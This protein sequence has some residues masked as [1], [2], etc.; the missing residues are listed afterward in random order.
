MVKTKKKC[1]E[2]TLEEIVALKRRTRKGLR[3]HL[4]QVVEETKVL[5]ESFDQGQHL[6]AVQLKETLEEQLDSLKKLD[7]EILNILVQIEGVSD[8]EIAE[9][10]QRAGDTRGEIKALSTSLSD[11]VS[12]KSRVQDQDSDL[13][14][15][16]S[17]LNVNNESPHVNNV[18]LPKLE[19]KRFTGKVE[20]WQEFWDSFK[21]AIHTNS[22]LSPVEKFSYLRGLLVGAA[23]TS[24]AGLSLTAAN[25]EAAIDILQ[26]RFGRKVA[27]ERAH[28]NDLLQVPSVYHEKD[29]VGLR[30]LYDTVEVHHRGLQALGVNATTYEGIVVPSILTK[31]PETVR[32]Q[33]TRGKKY[34]EWKMEELLKELLCEL[35]LREEHCFRKEKTER[36]ERRASDRDHRRFGG[37]P[38]SAS[39]L[40]A[41]TN[42][43]CAYCMGK[44]AHENCEN[45]KTVEGRRELLQF[46]IHYLPHHAVVRKDAKTTKV[47]VVYDASSK[48]GKGGVSLNDCLHVGPALSPLLFDILIRFREKRVALVGD[49]EKE[50]L[51]IVVNERDRDCLRF[52]WVKSV[53]SEQLD[54]VVYR[55]CRVVLE[56]T[57]HRFCLMQHS[58]TI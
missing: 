32:L 29:T 52:L 54:P 7:K 16:H 21:S 10:V 20:E 42:D 26:R 24:I 14:T 30:K 40:L 11:L 35:E 1:K 12:R 45:I 41:R 48:E 47:R 49:I 36:P 56:S 9:E 33:I 23:R 6:K 27:I 2:P 44:H 37:G 51:N 25:Y 38:P 17:G 53:D 18:R 50:F 19:T 5:L 34:E 4:Q 28:I 46:E 3:T 31:L 55:F 22:K 15:N 43:L 39:A 13:A 8:D 57:V 58:S